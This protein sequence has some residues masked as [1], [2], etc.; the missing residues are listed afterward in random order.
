MCSLWVNGVVIGTVSRSGQLITGADSSSP[1][2]SPV[3][4]PSPLATLHR[5]P[6]SLPSTPPCSSSAASLQRPLSHLSPARTSP[7]RL[8]PPLNTPAIFFTCSTLPAGVRGREAVSG[9]SQSG[10]RA[11]EAPRSLF[12]KLSSQPLPFVSLPHHRL[13]SLHIPTAFCGRPLPSHGHTH[14][15]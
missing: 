9:S 5:L 1:I 7:G 14:R 4:Q 15:S 11:A 12:W 6:P 8:L 2:P 13:C 3:V 10:P